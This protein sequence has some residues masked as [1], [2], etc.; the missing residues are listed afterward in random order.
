MIL[1]FL[2]G[3]LDRSIN[4]L[5]IYNRSF[6]TIINLKLRFEASNLI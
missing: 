6:F 1:N 2:Y 4:M 3:I 5:K